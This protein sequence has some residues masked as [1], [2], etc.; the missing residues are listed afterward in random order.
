MS[1]FISSAYG[2]WFERVTSKI[3]LKTDTRE[4]YLRAVVEDFTPHIAAYCP[5]VENN[6]ARLEGLSRR[7]RSAWKTH[8]AGNVPRGK[9]AA[10]G[11]LHRKHAV[12]ESRA[13]WKSGLE[14]QNGKRAWERR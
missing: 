1:N 7:E 5:R 11:T 8:R 9:R 13:R 2:M 12:P 14:K 3:D 10:Q 4:G 6:G